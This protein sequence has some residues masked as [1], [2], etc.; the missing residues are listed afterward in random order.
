MQVISLDD[1]AAELTMPRSGLRKWSEDDD[2]ECQ[3]GLG[4]LPERLAWH[5]QSE[6]HLPLAFPS[7]LAA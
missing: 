2:L 4:L 5:A 6:L 3:L 1:E 7:A